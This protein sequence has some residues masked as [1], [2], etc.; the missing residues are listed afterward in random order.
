MTTTPKKPDAPVDAHEESNLPEN[1]ALQKAFDAGD[2]ER[3]R[4]LVAQRAK[5]LQRQGA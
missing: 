2:W 3:F 5:R 1:D 4:E